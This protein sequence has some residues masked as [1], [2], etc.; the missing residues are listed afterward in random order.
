M[1]KSARRASPHRASAGRGSRR[2]SRRSSRAVRAPARAGS[3]RGA[4][5]T[6]TLSNASSPRFRTTRECRTGAPARRHARAMKAFARRTGRRDGRSPPAPRARRGSPSTPAPKRLAIERA[7]AD[8]S[9]EALADRLD[10]RAVPALQPAHFGVGV[11]HRDPGPLEHLRDGRLAH[12]DRPGE[13]ACRDHASRVMP[14]S[15]ASAPSSGSS[16][17][18]RIVK[19]SPLDRGRTIARRGPPSGTRQRNSRPPAIRHRDRLR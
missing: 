12:A 2:T 7:I 19:W 4:E 8:R 6:I 17:M 16:G 18:P 10:Q 13:R 3:R 11:E 15:R 1:T 9:R 5:T 14:A